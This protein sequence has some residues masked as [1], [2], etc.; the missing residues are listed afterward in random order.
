MKYSPFLRF[1][2]ILMALAAPLAA[3]PLAKS[4]LAISGTPEDKAPLLSPLGVESTGLDFV[5]PIDNTHPMRRLYASAMACGGVAVGDVDG[6][7]LPDLFFANGPASNRLFRQKSSFAFEDITASS[8]VGGG[9]YWGVGAA[10]ADVDRDGD[11]DL[12]VCNHDQPNQLFVNDGKGVF[13]EKASAFGL[14]LHDASHTPAFCDYDRDGDLDLFVL[15]NRYYHPRGKLPAD[16]PVLDIRPGKP[17]TVKKEYERYIK[18]ESKTPGSRPGTFT[19]NW[20]EYGRRDFL[21]RNNGDGTFSDVTQ[22]TGITSEGYGLSATWW[23]YNLD[24][25]P[26]LYVGNDFNSPDYFYR[27]NGNGTF[28]NIIVGAVPHTSWFSMG[29]DF[30]DLDENGWPD[31]LVADMS[32]TNHYK[33]KTAMG[34][35]SDS[36]EF[37][38]TAIPRQYM[39]NALYFN[40]GTNV[41]MEGAYLTGLADSDWTWTVKLADLDCDGRTD[42]LYTNGMSKNFN[43]SDSKKALDIR[44]GETQWDRHMRANTPPLKEQNRVYRNHGDYQF[45]DVSREWGFDHVGMSYACAHADLDRDGDLDLVVVNLEEPASVYRNNARDNRVVFDFSG[46]KSSLKGEGVSVKITAGGREQQRHLTLMRGYLAGHEPVVH[47]G[48]GDANTIERAEIQWPSGHRQEFANLEANTRYTI[49]EPEEQPTPVSAPEKA[50]TLYTAANL[51]DK[52]KHTENTFD[53]FLV[54]PL[55]PNKMSQFGPGLAVGDIDGDGRD[56]VALGGARNSPT[57]VCLQRQTGNF[58]IGKLV[59]DALFEDLGVLF[60]EADGDGDLDMF[61]VS[62]GSEYKPGTK[63]LHDRLYLNNGKGNFLPAKNAVPA[64]P[65]SG[66]VACAADFDRDG[67]LD[68][69]VGARLVPGQF[70]VTPKSC[71]L[72]NQNGRFSD[73]TDELAPALGSTGLVTSAVWSDANN[74]GW[75]DLLVTH[76]WGP[77]KFYRND[78]GKLADATKDAGLEKRLGWWNGIAGGDVDHDGDID[79]AVTNFGLNTKYHADPG[80]PAKLY[81]GD[82]EG[83]GEKHLVEAEYEDGILYPVRGRSCSSTAMPHLADK[84]KTY[85]KFALADLQEI[86][87]PKHLEDSIELQCNELRSG[88]LINDGAGRFSFEALP[89]LAQIAPGFGVAIQELTGDVHPDIFVAQNF[90]GP[91]VETGHMD[92]GISVLLRGDGKGGFAAMEPLAS[93]IVAQGDATAVVFPDLNGD[94]WPDIAM[95][96]NNGPTRTF[97][98][99][100]VRGGKLVKVALRGPKGNPSAVGARVDLVLKSGVKLMREITAGGGY[101]SQDSTVAAFTTPAGDPVQKAVVRWPDGKTS[102]YTKDLTNLDLLLRR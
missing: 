84:F 36:A 66:S 32:G 99:R 83:N 92:G 41:F 42:V 38:A 30:G 81:Y 88:V 23:D 94:R 48:L 37:L 86:Y 61:I 9:D 68:L 69:F 101:L 77:V 82:F 27:N 65:E 10:F 57:Q 87:T 16:E 59:P 62:G 13:E 2:V 96:M 90:Y 47:F 46:R 31:F 45:H 100:P 93:G 4:P 49:E 18:I 98:R 95:G 75:V 79:Y 89:A 26:D 7:G 3:A 20:T 74:D 52:V 19:Y 43:E 44:V 60:F 73:A 12:Y 25:W 76:E 50:P 97:L 40:T 1:P 39:R 22:A 28:T 64:I 11:V 85:H 70:P 55:L 51:L 56:D 78:K 17:V 8:G 58:A 15:T 34:A 67:D 33:Q 6:D 29:A 14:A 35:M 63:A 72:V 24:G 80:H 54:Q 71:L 91:Q 21:Y 53:D 102:T 5:T